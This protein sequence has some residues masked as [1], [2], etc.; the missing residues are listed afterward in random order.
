MLNEQPHEIPNNTV[1]V[2]RSLIGLAIILVRILVSV[3]LIQ[4]LI[5]TES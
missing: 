1:N 4:R 2:H 5:Y 3:L